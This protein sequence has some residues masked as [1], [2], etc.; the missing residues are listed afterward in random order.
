MVFIEWQSDRK[1]LQ[2]GAFGVTFTSYISVLMS[3]T[4]PGLKLN[5]LFF[6]SGF[7]AGASFMSF[8]H[9]IFNFGDQPF[10]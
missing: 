9:C 8:Q 6:R 4:M 7:F 2:S 3:L 1:R 5:Y 10:K